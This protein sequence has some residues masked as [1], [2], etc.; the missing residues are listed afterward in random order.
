MT[1]NI[2]EALMLLCQAD[3]QV[4]TADREAASLLKGK[5]TSEGKEAPVNAHLSQFATKVSCVEL[6][7]CFE[8]FVANRQESAQMS[9]TCGGNKR[10]LLLKRLNGFQSVPLFAIELVAEPDEQTT[11]AE[12]GRGTARL[13]H[14]FKNQLGGL[15]LYAAYLK[16][17]FAASPDV[18]DGL[19]IADKIVQA[20]NE[21]A[22]NAS[23]IVKLS[24]PLGLKLA[25]VNFNSLVEQTLNQLRTKIDERHLNLETDLAETKPLLL[26]SQ[27][28]LWT[29]SV[30][31]A[32]A[33]EA[34]PENGRLM[35]KLQNDDDELAFSI[36][37]EGEQ[38]T[39]EQRNTLFALLTNER[40]NQNS[41]NLTLA[42][43]IVEAHDG[44]IAI[45]QAMPSGSEVRLTF[46]I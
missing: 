28:M 41:L 34:S 23:I 31:I 27:Q 17:R 33:I 44:K 18:A 36:F 15:K 26:D 25:E 6:P 19:E 13:I 29:L 22:E 30:L 2:P 14:D 37:D 21:M 10:R 11:M 9:V 12:V 43:R 32:R 40:M 46:G 1:A 24:R 7:E 8:S 45:L 39:E 38:L 16:K 3:G 5:Q 4:V 20:L 35:L 42:R